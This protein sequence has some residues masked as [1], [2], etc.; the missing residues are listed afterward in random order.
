MPHRIPLET[1]NRD[2]IGTELKCRAKM[3]LTF[4]PWLGAGGGPLRRRIGRRTFR[5]TPTVPLHCTDDGLHSL[6][7]NSEAANG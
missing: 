4:E 2:E 3:E 1:S 6:E 5:R 7:R